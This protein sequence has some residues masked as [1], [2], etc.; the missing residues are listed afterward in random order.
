MGFFKSLVSAMGASK[1]NLKAIYVVHPTVGL[2][3]WMLAVQVRVDSG[4]FSRVVYLNKASD[5]KKYFSSPSLWQ[6]VPPHVTDVDER[7]PQAAS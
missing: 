3:A 7:P 4:I 5:L 2:K 1:R 6:D